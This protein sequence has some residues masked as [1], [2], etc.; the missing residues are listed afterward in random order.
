MKGMK[1]IAFAAALL[2]LVPAAARWA[3]QSDKARDIL[4]GL[5]AFDLFNPAHVN[6]LSDENYRGDSRGIE[7]TTVDL[8]VLALFAAQ[9]LRG[10]VTPPQTRYLPFRALYLLAVVI[11][12]VASPDYER[13]FFSVW[14]L[15][16]MYFAF[17]VLAT[18]FS[19]L[20]LVRSALTGLAIGVTTQGLI[21]LQ[22]K[23][24]F[25]MVRVMGSQSH[26]NSLAMIVN[27]IA[28]V[29]F[30]L[31]LTGAARRIAIVVFAFAAMCDV[32][33][34]SRGGMMM[35]VLAAVLVTAGSL[36]RGFTARK[37]KIVA[38]LIVGGLL[39]F[40]KSAETIIKRFTEA[41]KES[42][43]ARHL[44]NLAAKEMASEHP[45]GIG[46]NM[47]SWVLEHG[48]YAARL[49]IDPGDKNGIAHHIYWLTA[50]ETGYFGLVAYAL[51]LAAVLWRAVSAARQPGVRGEIALGISVGLVITYLQ[52]TAEWIARQT[53]MAYCFWMLAAMV[54]ALDAARPRAT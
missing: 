34:L 28:P 23:Y 11:S 10:T 47:Y 7:V 51:L 42:E 49:G 32:F 21:A 37:M 14:K 54:A 44:F 4:V 39:A 20:R 40:A 9:K 50:A 8:M 35:F 5:I 48:G 15:V 52:G 43:E 29:A 3:W 45:F 13:S 19:E 25:H 6:F 26:P 27:F 12:L 18:A 41:P 30:A 16:R 31:I 46:I 24:V 2:V 53:T 22:Q 1:W 36:V 33:S 17:S 38:T